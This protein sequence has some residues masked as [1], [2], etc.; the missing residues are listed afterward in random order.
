[1][2][3]KCIKL[4]FDPDKKAADNISEHM[5]SAF[6]ENILEERTPGCYKPPVIPNMKVFEAVVSC[7]G[8]DGTV[9][10]VPKLSGKI[11]YVIRIHQYKS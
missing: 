8:D 7:I 3:T 4:N 1:M 11:F 10:V 6:K 9:F 5:V 2:V